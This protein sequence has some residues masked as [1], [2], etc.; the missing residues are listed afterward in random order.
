MLHEADTLQL[1]LNHSPLAELVFDTDASANKLNRQTLLALEQAIAKLEQTPQVRGL[2]IRSAKTHFMVGADVTE[3]LSLVAQPEAELDSWLQWV[4]QLFCRIESLPFPTLCALSSHTLGGGCELAL[5]TDFRLA[6]TSL[7][8][9]LP[10]TKL[11][12]MPGWGGSVRLPRLIGLEPAMKAITTGRILTS[13][14][15]LHSGWV[16]AVAESDDMLALARRMLTAAADG[17]LDWQA[18]RL[19][20]LKALHYSTA[21]LQLIQTMANDQLQHL[22]STHYPAPWHA[23]TA[24]IAS[25]AL[26]VESALAIERQHFLALTRTP[27][28][29]ALVGH[30]L[31]EQRVKAK[32]RATPPT[33][34]PHQI[35]ILGAGIMGSGIGYQCLRQGFD[36]TVHDMHAPALLRCQQTI[37]HLL[38]QDL[39]KQRLTEHQLVTAL[40]R[41]HLTS[42]ADDLDH[43]ELIIEAVA[44]QLDIKQQVLINCERHL[45]PQALLTSNTSAIPI[46]QLASRLQRPEQLCGLHFFNPVPR[47][48]LVEVVRAARSSEAC[49]AHAC[50]FALA[51]GKTPVVVNDGPGFFVNRV[52]FAYLSAFRQLVAAGTNPYQ[53]DHL[54]EQQFGWPM[55]PARLLDTIGLDIAFHAANILAAAFPERMTQPERDALSALVA[56]GHL[57]K[58]TGQGFYRYTGNELNA[59][60]TEPWAPDAVGNP[61]TSAGELTDSLLT[62]RLIIPLLHEA[63]RC[64]EEFIIATPA[65]GD[66]ALVLGLGFPSFRGGPFR[67]LQQWGLAHAIAAAERHAQHGGLYAVPTTLYEMVANQQGFY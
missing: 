21:E 61:A 50:N 24:M 48:G 47:M 44:E 28:A 57:G 59:L 64:L 55:G 60:P 34:L 2:L 9:G 46:S 37:T 45:S 26:N 18:H 58:K 15:A 6:D 29:E 5:C 4:N 54:M 7:Q 25:H 13:S 16:D 33:T 22:V 67:Y 10:E 40:N 41:L 19:R 42:N 23:L 14:A 32:A 27:Q 62:E 43:S 17:E 38:E 65:E 30:F 39:A 12:I 20:K 31:N 56:D 35:S 66:L 53:I 11:G 52:L 1:Y 8:I 3:F 51:L 36:T 63:V 49:V